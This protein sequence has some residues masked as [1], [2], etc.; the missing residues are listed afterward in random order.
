MLGKTVTVQVDRPLGS[1]HPNHSDI[2]YPVN[3]G[4]VEG[5]AA[6]DG[7]WQDVYILGVEEPVAQF[8]GPV[9]AI[10]HR[11]DDAEEK[12]VAAPAGMT[13]T[14]EEIAQKLHFQERYFRTE[15]RM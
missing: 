6:G 10:V 3:Y 1:R 8:T 14:K 2:L 4:F 12:W 9:I 5:I 15:I 13:F 11:F 7:E